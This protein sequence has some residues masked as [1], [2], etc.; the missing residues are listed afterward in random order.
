MSLI[1]PATRGRPE[2]RIISHSFRCQDWKFT[3]ETAIYLDHQPPISNCLYQALELQLLWDFDKFFFLHQICQRS[4]ITSWLLTCEHIHTTVCLQEGKQLFTI[5]VHMMGLQFA[6]ARKKTK[7]KT[8]TRNNTPITFNTTVV[9]WT[10]HTKQPM[11]LRFTGH[12][13]MSGTVKIDGKANDMAKSISTM[14]VRNNLFAK[15]LLRSQV[16]NKILYMCTSWVL[17]FTLRVQNWNIL[18]SC[19]FCPFSFGVG[20]RRTGRISYEHG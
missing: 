15:L 6:Q 2:W 5:I 9:K 19:V 1:H 3:F 20:V 13:M 10:H 11:D 16:E 12:K 7:N 8:K 4:E 17:N 18:K 14:Q